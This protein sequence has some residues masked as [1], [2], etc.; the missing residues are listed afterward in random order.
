[1]T[2]NKI[3]SCFLFTF[4]FLF[5]ITHAS[6]AALQ[7]K[8][9]VR[10]KGQEVTTIR[11]YGIVSGLNGTGDDL[12]SYS[13]A[14]RAIL[15][16]LERSGMA[17][18]SEKGIGTSRNN[19][20][21]EVT[22]TIPAEGGRDGDRLDCTVA[23]VGNAKTLEGGS[24]SVVMLA[25]PVPFDEKTQPLGMAT[26]LISIE[27]TNYP[28]VGRIK[29]GCRLT[30][31][32][33][34][35]Y[36]KDGN[37]TLVIKKETS[38]PQ[39]AINVAESINL[40]LLGLG[41]IARAVNSHYVVVRVPRK[42]Y[43]NPLNFVADVLALELQQHQDR[44]PVPRVTINERVGAIAID[45]NVEV[46]PT[47]V[48]YWNI[49]AEIPPVLQPGEQEQLPRQFIDVDTDTKFRQMNGE[50]VQNMKLK[51]LQ[52][53]LDAVRVTPRDMI[54]IIKILQSQNAIVGEVV[55]VE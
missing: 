39:M 19:A 8:N 53:S 24:L 2:D 6:A 29:N 25:A 41:D 37:I 34:N 14:A 18:A 27:R 32:F 44:P 11:G 31:D 46:K 54:E 43:N 26:G 52:A 12:K 15:R 48:T 9:V 23:S 4:L 36:I 17:G 3:F 55:F 45:E 20:L 10:I 5:A 51:A 49:V 47:L 13:P 7:I 38:D 33:I 1:M 22:A 35:P 42:E 28:N 21:V 30:A 16:Q 40:G 50:N